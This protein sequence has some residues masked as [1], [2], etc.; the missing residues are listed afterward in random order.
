MVEQLRHED[1]MPHVGKQMRFEGWQ[2][3]LRLAAIDL[4]PQAAAPGFAVTPF[5]LLFH[6]P[7]GDILPEGMYRADIEDGP[8]FE[9]YIMPIHTAVPGRQEYQVVFN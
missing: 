6:G 4:H 5:T 7:V 9:F 3:T 8:S 2:G 1:F